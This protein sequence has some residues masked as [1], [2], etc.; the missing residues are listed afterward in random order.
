MF[1]GVHADQEGRSDGTEGCRMLRNKCEEQQCRIHAAAHIRA[2]HSVEVS[3]ANIFIMKQKS[4]SQEIFELRPD[5]V[6]SQTCRRAGGNATFGCG[7]LM[8]V[9]R[10]CIQR[11]HCDLKSICDA[12]IQGFE[13]S[14]D[15]RYGG[16]G[17]L[18]HNRSHICLHFSEFVQSL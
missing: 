15:E 1:T 14:L 5:I 2:C 10:R 17:V 8:K 4:L 3:E 16:C 13:D 6:V 18:R 12:Y 7:V 9:G 11:E